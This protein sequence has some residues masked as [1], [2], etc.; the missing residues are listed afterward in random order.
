MCRGAKCAEEKSVLGI[1][2][3]W[4]AECYR[5]RIVLRSKVFQGVK[6]VKC[7]GEQSVA[8]EQS[9]HQ[10]DY[11]LSRC[12]SFVHVFFQFFIDFGHAVF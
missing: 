6:C 11:N 4:E 10:P 7:S 1:K 3:S 8:K 5:E 12:C 2:V 9:V